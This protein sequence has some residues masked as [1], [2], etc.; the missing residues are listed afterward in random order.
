MNRRQALR[1]FALSSLV[2]A[3]V[4][5]SIAFCQQEPANE[6]ARDPAWERAIRRGLEYLVG[7]Q[8]RSG[9]WTDDAYPTAV[10][11]LAGIAL[12]CSGST[13]I[14]GPYS[15]QIRHTADYLISKCR[16]NGL[17]GD[18]KRDSRYTYGHGFALL[19]LSQVFGEEEDAERRQE[20][21]EILERAVEFSC[22]AQTRSGGWGYVSA[23]EDDFD[24]GSTTVTQVQALR[25]CRNAGIIVPKKTIDSAIAYI[26]QCKNSDGGISYSST[27]RGS[28]RPP[29]TAAALAAPL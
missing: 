19:F 14:Q 23:K 6:G 12:I 15:E 24:E 10:T 17:I 18:P 7:Q 11:S 5:G 22:N 20:L 2:A 13:T 4:P 27:S 9:H 25:A 3:G 1:Q 21:A 26:Y 29:I 8:S 16:K 28:S